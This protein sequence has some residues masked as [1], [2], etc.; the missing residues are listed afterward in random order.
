[1]TK[2]LPSSILE[3]KRVPVCRDRHVIFQSQH[4][5]EMA[6]IM[7]EERFYDKINDKNDETI[8]TIIDLLRNL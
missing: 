8:R 5:S 3:K 1:M 2:I 4:H 7:I 6:K